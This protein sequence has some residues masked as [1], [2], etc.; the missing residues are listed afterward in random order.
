MSNRGDCRT[1][2]ATPGLFNKYQRLGGN[3]PVYKKIKKIKK[4]DETHKKVEGRNR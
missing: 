3:I 4:I 2:P 1:A